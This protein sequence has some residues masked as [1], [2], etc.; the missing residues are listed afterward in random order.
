MLFESGGEKYC[1][2]T[3]A[4]ISSLEKRIERIIKRDNLTH[5]EAMRRINAQHSDD[6]Y[7]DRADLVLYNNGEQRELENEIIR[8]INGEL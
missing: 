1:K 2:K 3:V 7:T 8:L 4:V 5:N 6:Y